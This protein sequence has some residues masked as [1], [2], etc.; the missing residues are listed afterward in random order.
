MNIYLYNTLG[1]KKEEFMPL[2]PGF[3]GIYCCGPTVYDYAHIGNMRT[4]IFE[5]VL[6]RMFLYN[7]YK[8]KHIMNITD[9]GHLTSDADEGE[10]KLMKALKREGKEPTVKALMELADKYTKAFFNDTDRLNI[11]RPD[12]VP[13]AT[14]HIQEMIDQIKRIE[15]NGYT[16]KTSVGLIYDTSKFKKYTELAKQNLEQIKAGARVAVDKERRNPSDFALWVTNQPNHVMQWDSPWGR[17]FPGWHI[18][19]SS[20]SMKHL[21]EQ[22]DIHCGGID[23]ISIH[24]SNEIA[25][26]EGATGKKWVNYWLHGE[27]LVLEKEKMS[28][29]GGGFVTLQTIIDRGFNPLSYRHLCLTAQ[30]RSPLVFSWDNLKK[31]EQAYYSLKNRVSLSKKEEGKENEELSK[32]FEE[33]FH[34]KINDDMDMPRAMAIVWNMIKSDLSGQEKIKLVKE[35]D[36]VLGLG[37]LEEKDLP[38]GALELIEEREAA[39]EGKDWKKADEIRDKLKGMEIILEDTEDG[40]VWKVK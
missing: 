31:A 1:R 15:K 27:F 3:V 7:G 18:E 40:T 26:A 21:G 28:K 23:H 4:Y 34:Q 25:Q 10:D 14:E 30:Y 2:K 36:K 13:K 33:D 37:L 20:M 16:Y 24:H 6:K 22:F 9:V 19:C 11:I 32:R 5:D 29:S 8:V 39:R 35:F 17:G 38:E 12:V